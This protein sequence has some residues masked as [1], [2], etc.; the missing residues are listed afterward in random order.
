[1]WKYKTVDV[2]S[3]EALR[4]K[5]SGWKMLASLSS[6]VSGKVMFERRENKIDRLSRLRLET[7]LNNDKE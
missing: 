6:L 2:D 5:A 4:L 1:M 7:A 3:V